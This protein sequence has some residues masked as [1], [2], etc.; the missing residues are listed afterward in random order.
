MKRTE[1]V[2]LSQADLEEAIK[3]WLIKKDLEDSAIIIND[4]KWTLNLRHSVST[5]GQGWGEV[6]KERF[7]VI[8]TREK[9]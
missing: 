4:N 1:T 9:E 3:D 5:H 6:D 2:E 8:A 7:W